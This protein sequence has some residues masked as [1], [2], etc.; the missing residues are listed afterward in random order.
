MHTMNRKTDFYEVSPPNPPN[1]GMIFVDHSKTGRSGHLGHALV[2]YAPGKIL[3]F[4]PNC[5]DANNGHCGDGWMEYK[6]SEDAGRSWSQ[7][8]QLEYSK[9]V[10]ESNQER[11]VMCEKAI[12]TSDGDILLF[13]LECGN[14]AATDFMWQPLAV[15]T[16]L[17]SSNGG[18]IWEEAKPVGNENG[19]IWDVLYHEGLIYVLEFC[20][21]SRI[22]WYGNL[23]EHHYSLYVSEDQGRSFIRRSILPFDYMN[24]GYGTLSFLPGKGLIA[25]VYNT[26]DET[27]LEYVI[28]KDAG[29]SW[30]EPQTAF[31]AK[32]IRN[33]QMTLFKNGF[34]M[35]GRSG[36]K[37]ED[38]IRGHFVLYTS[39]D[40]IHWDEGLYLQ[41]RTAGSGAYS[42]N[43][44]VH[45]PR[46]QSERLLIQ[47]SHAYEGKKTNIHHWW[48][49]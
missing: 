47:A 33:P 27:H 7:P 42:N 30:S 31:F 25:Y 36:S 37:G 20:N 28:S 44:L 14:A 3:A 13:N 24:R 32:Q 23:P 46:D 26:S 43:L 9:T 29:R 17:R 34:V 48:L 40:G 5:S 11:S 39:D 22:A 4:Y 6:R 19:R 8:F 41:M 38:K 16:V 35:H 1:S 21:D 15:P 12:C 49:S 10:Y 2:E 18:A 45:D